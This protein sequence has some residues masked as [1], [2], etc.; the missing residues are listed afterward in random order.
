MKDTVLL[1]V[2]CLIAIVLA[3]YF[4]MQEDTKAIEQFNKYPECMTT[5][6]PYLC[7][8]LKKRVER[9]NNDK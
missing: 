4:A 3:I 6:D 7:L 8:H 5:E 2:L 9:Y 1:V